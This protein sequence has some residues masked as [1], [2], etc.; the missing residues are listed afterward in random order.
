MIRIEVD[1]SRCS[2]HA[3]CFAASAELFPLDE[4]GYLAYEQR[5][6]DDANGEVADLGASW[7]PERAIR[8]VR[9]SHGA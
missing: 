2:G 3:R 9:D 6:V 1:K 5:E 8:V 4:E 7:C